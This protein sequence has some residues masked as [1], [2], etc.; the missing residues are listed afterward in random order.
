[1]V[2]C[3]MRNNQIWKTNVEMGADK[4]QFPEAQHSKTEVVRGL[5]L[6][7]VP[8]L[9]SPFFDGPLDYA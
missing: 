7:C 6:H 3:T 4:R 9:Q 2:L 5:L 8:D 1:M